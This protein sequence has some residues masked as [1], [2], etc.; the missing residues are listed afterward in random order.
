MVSVLSTQSCIFQSTDGNIFG[1]CPGHTWAFNHYQ[2][3]NRLDHQ[4]NRFEHWLSIDRRSV[5]GQRQDLL[6]GMWNEAKPRRMACTI[7]TALYR[8]RS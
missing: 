7:Y 4:T 1:R 5:R 8:V 6:S 2:G 3:T